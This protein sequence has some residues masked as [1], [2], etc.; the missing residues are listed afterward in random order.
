MQKENN[1]YLPAWFDLILYDA[2]ASSWR[3]ITYGTKWVS[4]CR[5]ILA[6]MHAN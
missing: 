1:E 5:N 3:L 2:T 4:T 6:L